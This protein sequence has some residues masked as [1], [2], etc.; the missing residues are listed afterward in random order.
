MHESC[1]KISNIYSV[2]NN[3]LQIHQFGVGVHEPLWSDPSFHFHPYLLQNLVHMACYCQ[4][5][6]LWLSE[7]HYT[8]P[9]SSPL[10]MLIYPPGECSHSTWNEFLLLYICS[11]KYNFIFNLYLTVSSHGNFDSPPIWA[12]AFHY[13]EILE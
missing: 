5:T 2:V 8:F 3:T 13:S 1:M 6:Y 12:L 11:K 7:Q 4:L 10:L 9:I